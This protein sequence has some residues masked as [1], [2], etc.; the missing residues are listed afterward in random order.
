MKSCCPGSCFQVHW[1]L[2]SL[3]RNKDASWGLFYNDDGQPCDQFISQKLTFINIIILE[4]RL[5]HMNFGETCSVYYNIKQKILE[6][7]NLRNTMESR[8]TLSKLTRWIHWCSLFSLN[9]SKPSSQELQ[10]YRWEA[11][12]LMPVFPPTT[13][14]QKIIL[15]AP[16]SALH[17]LYFC[18]NCVITK[19][20]ETN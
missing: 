7:S 6:F 9:K 1:L 10:V 14:A 8:K 2:S 20:Q 4:F 19:P 11:V 13:E 17:Y 18:T 12:F 5:Q 3:E 16:K 15:L